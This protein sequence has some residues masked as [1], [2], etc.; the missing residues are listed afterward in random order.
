MDGVE[1]SQTYQYMHGI[2]HGRGSRVSAI[3]GTQNEVALGQRSREHVCVLW[4]ANLTTCDVSAS[5]GALICQIHARK[6]KGFV[7]NGSIV[8]IRC[9]GKDNYKYKNKSKITFLN[10]QWPE[11]I[12]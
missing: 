2:D 3:E 6:I 1:G 12:T 10:R 11:K 8:H 4:W 7:D 5:P 9:G